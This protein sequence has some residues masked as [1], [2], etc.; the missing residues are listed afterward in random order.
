MERVLDEG[1]TTKSRKT[2]GK[3]DEK[4]Q[5]KKRGNRTNTNMKKGGGP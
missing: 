1:E 3:G 5:E 4:K 2:W